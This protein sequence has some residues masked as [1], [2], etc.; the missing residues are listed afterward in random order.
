MLTSVAYG[1]AP[2]NAGER[3]ANEGTLINHEARPVDAA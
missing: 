1:A 2:A 3:T